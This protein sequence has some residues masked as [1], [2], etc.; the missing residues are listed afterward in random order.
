[1]NM[2]VIDLREKLRRSPMNRQLAEVSSNERRKIGDRR[3]LSSATNR[4]STNVQRIWLTPGERTL[5]EDLYLL[6]DI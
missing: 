2:N 4:G 5:I 3:I 6:D 1:M